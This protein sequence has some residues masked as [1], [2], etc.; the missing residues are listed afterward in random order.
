[1]SSPPDLHMLNLV[2]RDMGAAVEFYRRLDVNVV[3]DDPTAPHVELRLP[4]GFSLEL[5]TAE[6]AALWHA[7][8]L[9]P[10]HGLSAAP[11]IAPARSAP[12]W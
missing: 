9:I 12:R 2:V 11:S 8:S 1:M 4:S 6:S 3:S 7:G 10:D 5:D